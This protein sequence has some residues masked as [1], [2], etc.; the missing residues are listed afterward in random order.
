M[1]M[2]SAIRL[3]Q[4]TALPV[5]PAYRRR[6]PGRPRDLLPDVNEWKPQT[7]PIANIA[8]FFVEGMQGNGTNRSLRAFD[9]DARV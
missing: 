5:Q 7:V 4:R 3:R 8:G 6:S 9:D 2:A 1:V